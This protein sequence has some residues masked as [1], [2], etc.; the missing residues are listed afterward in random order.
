MLDLPDVN[1]LVA[2]ALPRHIHHQPATSWWQNTER[3]ALTPFTETA[4]LRLLMNP[5]LTRAPLTFGAAQ[6]VTAAIATNTRAEFLAD[7]ISLLHVSFD[8]SVIRGAKQVTDAHLVE[9]ARRNN[10]QLVTLDAKMP[11]SLG[12]NAATSIT[13]IGPGPDKP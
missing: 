9:L 11:V 2:L 10:A 8:T 1:I 5:A 12:P 13:V 3:Y 4:L 6:E 7:N